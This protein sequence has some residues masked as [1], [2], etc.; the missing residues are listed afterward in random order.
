MCQ[1]RLQHVDRAMCHSTASS[2]RTTR[3]RRLRRALHLCAVLKQKKNGERA[4]A[5]DVAPQLSRSRV[6]CPE[7]FAVASSLPSLRGR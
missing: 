6:L 4:G 3:G 7:P 1:L 5:A 2:I